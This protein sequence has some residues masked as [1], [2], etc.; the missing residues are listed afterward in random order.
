MFTIGEFSKITGLTVKTLRFYHER[1]LLVPTRVERATGYRYYDAQNIDTARVIRALRDLEVP[2]DSIAAI[3]QECEDDRDT[4]TFLMGHRDEL[5]RKFDHYRNLVGKIDQVITQQRE[6]RELAMSGKQAYEIQEK[7]IPPQL[8]AGIRMK[9]RYNECGPVFARL[10]KAVGRYIGGKAMCLMYDGEYREVDADFEPAFPVRKRV[11]VEGVDIRELPVI[12][13]VS[14]IHRGPY[15]TLG[16][17]YERILTY[18]RDKG[19]EATLPSR[20]VYLK[21]PGMIF[22]GNPK[23]YLTEIQL[24]VTGSFA[25]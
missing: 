14:L 13:C 8:I 22:K 17:S 7:D 11:E 4:I 24:P 10:G 9:G 18:A 25:R 12:R 6:I 2:L 21:G 5:A 16:R 20:E 15:D 23:K 19:Y 1:G 3:L